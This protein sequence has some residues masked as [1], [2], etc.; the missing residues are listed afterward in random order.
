MAG[1]RIMT[2]EQA[3][4]LFPGVAMDALREEEERW[5]EFL[6][7]RVEEAGR[8]ISS[9]TGCSARYTAG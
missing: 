5:Y 1:A 6:Q 3:R 9:T 8:Q 7:L 2:A 4:T